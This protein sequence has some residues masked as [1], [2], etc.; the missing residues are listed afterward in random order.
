MSNEYKIAIL[1]P[2][3]GRTDALSRS[4]MG[5]LNR[6]LDLDQIQ[7]LFAFDNDDDLGKTHFS[8]SLEPWLIEKGVD[9]TAMEFEP[10]GYGRLNEY[11]NALAH[12]SSADWLFFWNDDALMDTSGWDRIIASYT[13]QFKLLAVHTHKDHPY[14][15]FPIVPR[16]WLNQLGYLSPHPLT[17]AWLS[18]VAYQ[19]DIWERIEVW[20][21]HDRHDLTG[22]NKD[23]TFDN[24]KMDLLEGNP[25]NPRDF[26][27]PGWIQLRI[28]ESEQISQWMKTQGLD[29]S[30]WE[31][32]KSGKQ[33]PWEKL[34]AN[35]VNNQMVQFTIAVK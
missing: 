19:L 21:T 24:R 14:S 26:H 4:V 10:L 20:V 9:Y 2:T 22:N 33:Y 6:A 30:W 15:I 7:I 18:Q 3:R 32:V 11:I 29:I 1:L 16:E 8:E 23:E 25:K 34:R 17:D 12:E 28:K 5:L 13:G 35:D 31:N 27:N